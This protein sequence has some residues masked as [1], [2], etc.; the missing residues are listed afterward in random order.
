MTGSG[1]CSYS[2]HNSF[3]VP[4]VLYL[5]SYSD[6]TYTPCILQASRRNSALFIPFFLHSIYFSTNSGSSISPSPIK[7]TSMKS[8]SGS[9]LNAQG[10]PAIIRGLSWLL[11]D[12]RSGIC[13]RSSMFSTVVNDISYWRVK[14]TISI[15]LIGILASRL[16]KGTPSSRIISSMSTAGAKTL[17]QNIF[18]RLLSSW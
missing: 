17:W 9:G 12:A 13:A 2:L 5:I 1:A 8:V 3:I 18:S 15:S 11:S 4:S 6:G 16:T 14:P 10:P 7:N